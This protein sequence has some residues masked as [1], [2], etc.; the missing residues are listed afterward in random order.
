MCHPALVV[1]LP[2]LLFGPNS[3]VKLLDVT[4]DTSEP[5]SGQLAGGTY[6]AHVNVAM[7]RVHATLPLL[8]V[9]DVVV[10]EASAAADFPQTR[11][12]AGPN[13]A[14][15]VSGHAFIASETT[16]PE[17]LPILAN[18]VSIPSTGGHE[19]KTA[20]AV[21][22]PDDGSVI[23][24]R[25]V[26][27]DSVGTRDAD[28]SDAS[29]FAQVK[30]LCLLPDAVAD[31]C[32]IGA[33]LVRSQANSTANAGGAASSDTGTNLVELQILGQTIPVTP[34]R[35]TVLALPGLGFVVLNEQ[36]CDDGGTPPTCAGGTHSGL[37]VRAV[38]V[39]LTLPTAPL[40]AGAEIIVAEA[41]SDATFID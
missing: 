34:P 3:H 41:H 2:D 27:S 36:V 6:E 26:E 7:I 13:A 5:P 29:S 39:V 30:Q 19:N 31:G 10:S 16:D 15:A 37:T 11:L 33:K 1:D 28:S 35:N 12:C 9:I 17:I 21:I 23:T 20:N 4:G 38:H 22:L 18:F 32:T 24:S 14:Q 40:L 25:A 8:G